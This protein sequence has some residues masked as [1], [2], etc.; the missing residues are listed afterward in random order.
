VITLGSAELQVI[1]RGRPIA[2]GY[3][4]V[5]ALARTVLP[6]ERL[7][8]VEVRPSPTH[9]GVAALLVRVGRVAHEFLL[10]TANAEA[11]AAEMRR[12]VRA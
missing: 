12:Q 7:Q 10:D 9:D 3:K 6:L 11:V 2:T 4:P 8:S 5:H 1:H